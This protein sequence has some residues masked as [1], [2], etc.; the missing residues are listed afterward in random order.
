MAGRTL[1]LHAG[2]DIRFSTTEGFINGGVHLCAGLED[3]LRGRFAAH[4]EYVVLPEPI[5]HA[6]VAHQKVDELEG[7][8]AIFGTLDELG[9]V[10]PTK[11]ALARKLDVS[12]VLARLFVDPIGKPEARRLA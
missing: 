7:V 5:L 3:A 9:A 4:S 11:R 2:G 10:S 12:D 6:R 1:E 8:L